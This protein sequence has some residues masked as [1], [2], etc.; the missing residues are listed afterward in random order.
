MIVFHKALKSRYLTAYLAC[1]RVNLSIN[2]VLQA[3][4]SVFSLLFESGL[5]IKYRMKIELVQDVKNFCIA[6]LFS[7]CESFIRIIMHL[8]DGSEN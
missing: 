6:A 1:N 2:M 8:T 7:L 5:Q 3:S 4:I